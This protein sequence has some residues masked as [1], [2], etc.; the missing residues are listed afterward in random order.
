MTT[1]VALPRTAHYA[2]A[3]GDRRTRLPSAV[4]RFHCSGCD[5]TA[6]GSATVVAAPTRAGRMLA[7]AFGLPPA[8]RAVPL[9]ITIR[10]EPDGETWERAFGA[11]RLVTRQM[12][13]WG[14]VVEHVG[15]AAVRYRLEVVD[16]ALQ[17]RSVAATVGG[18]V[19]PAALAPHV[20][21]LVTAPGDGE[22][23]H[24]ST[25]LVVPRIGLVA[26]FDGVLREEPL[27]A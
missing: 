2:R 26:A 6:A 25:E 16:G 1:L 14:G 23:L 15:S 5:V 13:T 20:I 27:P 22:W 19:V 17:A 12:P 4:R 10:R 7:R 8:G 24:V 21:T 18:V 3:L 9:R 11:H